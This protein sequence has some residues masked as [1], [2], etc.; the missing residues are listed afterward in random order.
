MKNRFVTIYLLVIFCFAVEVTLAQTI[1]FTPISSR[2]TSVLPKPNLPYEAKYTSSTEV[3]EE[4]GRYYMVVNDL[5]GGWP[6]EK[7]NVALLESEDLESWEW[8][9][10]PI[11]SSDDLSFQLKKPNGFVTSIVKKKDTYYA[12]MDVLDHDKNIGI[13]LA[14]S[15]ALEGPWKIYPEMVLKPDPARWDA[16]AL[17]GADVVLKDGEFVMYYMGLLKDTVNGET[18]IGMAESTDGI[19]WQRGDNP[20]LTKSEIGFDSYKVEA[21]KVIKE[22]DGYTMIYRSDNGDGTYG[23][24]SAYGIARSKDGTVWKRIQNDYILSEKDV[25]N[26][27]NVW[28]CGLIKVDNTYHLFLEYDGPP[29]YDTRVNHAIYKEKEQ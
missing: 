13:G 12:F 23:G 7:I 3:F 5:V 1:K 21:P 19:V 25:S 16:Y 11:F 2:T 24:D 28:A 27:Y 8:F 17:T 6:C 18:A 4:N 9:E 22:E 14:T 10:T 29:V 20:I 15:N 26:W